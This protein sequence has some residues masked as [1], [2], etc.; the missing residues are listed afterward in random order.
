MSKSSNNCPRWLTSVPAVFLAVL[1]TPALL[2]SLYVLMA[3]GLMPGGAGVVLAGM[4]CVVLLGGVVRLVT[5]DLGPRAHAAA[6][7]AVIAGGAL[8]RFAVVLGCRGFVQLEDRGIFIRFVELLEQGGLNAECLS[9]LSEWY[10]YNVWIHRA[11]PLAYP[12]RWLFGEQ[13]VLAFQL[14]SAMLSSAAMVVFYALAS[15]LLQEKGR[16]AALAVYAFFPLRLWNVLEY[17][18]RIQIEILILGVLLLVVKQLRGCTRWVPV[19]L[20]GAAVGLILFLLNLQRGVDLLLLLFFCAVVF[21]GQFRL[22]ALSSKFRL[23]SGLVLIPVMIYLPL[24]LSFDSWCGKYDLKQM[25]SGFS[26]FMARGW[27]LE[28]L[29]EF[30]G[31]YEQI[32]KATPV[33]LKGKVMRAVV[34]SQL[35]YHP[36]LVFS[37]LLPAKM[38]KYFLVGSATGMEQGLDQAGL[39]IPARIFTGQRVVFAP[40]FLLLVILSSVRM[41]AGGGEPVVWSSL[42]M[43]PLLACGVFVVLGESSPYY[44]FYVHAVLVLVAGRLWEPLPETLQAQRRLVRRELVRGCL[45]FA[46]LYAVAGI[47]APALAVLL[48]PEFTFHDISRAE[49]TASWTDERMSP[50]QVSPSLEPYL[51][52]ISLPV[53]PYSAGETVCA[54][55]PLAGAEPGK[56]SFYLWRTHASRADMNFEVVVLLN[57]N[58]IMSRPMNDL[59]GIS[60]MLFEASGELQLCLR[61]HEDIEDIAVPDDL[62]PPGVQWGYVL[63]PAGGGSSSENVE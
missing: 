2:A 4:V 43:F 54:R 9:V 49:I 40:I 57:G 60:H 39:M 15:E 35:K 23:A 3:R 37:R 48:P 17:S 22:P 55:L 53:R 58:E 26:G 16:R 52:R 30:D 34:F 63:Y 46:S 11:F 44:S 20:R 45:L 24:V 61:C 42:I 38:A 31:K 56:L 8:V 6:V 25:D 14:V 28:T 32:D 36:R 18:H 41:S 7:G 27:S 51:Q 13:H 33:W 1:L 21:C 62:E 50:R 29:G 47:A 59:P 19:A 5:R 12:L 10:E